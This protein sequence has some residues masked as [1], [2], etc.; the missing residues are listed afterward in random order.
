MKGQREK[1]FRFV[2]FCLDKYYILWYRL[3]QIQ[4]IHKP[5]DITVN[6]VAEGLG[7]HGM[8]MRTIDEY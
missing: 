2:Q 8:G 3:R 4:Y 5:E 6:S 1:I 7:I